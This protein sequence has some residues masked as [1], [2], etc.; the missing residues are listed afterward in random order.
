[1][2]RQIPDVAV[3]VM[4]FEVGKSCR[5]MGTVSGMLS[6]GY[7]CFDCFIF[8]DNWPLIMQLLEEGEVV[9]DH[10][11]QA[12]FTNALTDQVGNAMWHKV[13]FVS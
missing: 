10:S 7:F 5:E 3:C 9:E 4:C 12:Q 8:A 6:F 13:T 2:M 1:M 11:G